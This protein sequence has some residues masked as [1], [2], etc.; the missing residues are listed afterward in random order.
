[1]RGTLHLL[2]ANDLPSYVAAL[3]HRPRMAESA[4]WETSFGISTAEVE[5]MLAGIDRALRNAVLNRQELAERV[6]AETGQHG[7]RQQL[8]GSWGTFLKPAAFDGNLCFAPGESQKVRFT[9]PATWLPTWEPVEPETAIRDVLRRYLQT[10]GPATREN[11]ARWFGIPAAPAGRLLA[12]LG[13][14]TTPVSVGEH[15]R[16]HW[17]LAADLPTLRTAEADPSVHLRPGFDQY[18]VNGPR[19]VDE[20]LPQRRKDDIFRPQGWIFPVLLDGRIAGVWRHE[21]KGKRLL[22]TVSP[23]GRTNAAIRQRAALQAERLATF[24]GGE[25]DIAWR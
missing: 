16:I 19:D 1:M 22:V 18:V 21:R 24:L 7:L 11:V 10:Y 23:F 9:H 20:I 5:A 3:S 25:L 17:A 15:S 6:A 8:V 13:D 12:R 14:E 4:S 2:P